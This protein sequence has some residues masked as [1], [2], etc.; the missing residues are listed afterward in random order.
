MVTPVRCLIELPRTVTSTDLDTLPMVAVIV[1]FL[2]F[3]RA[4]PPES[5]PFTRPFASI[6]A[7]DGSEEVH[8][9]VPRSALS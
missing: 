3:Q 5:R 4:V 8:T 6:V 9:T 2:V 7:I 1:T